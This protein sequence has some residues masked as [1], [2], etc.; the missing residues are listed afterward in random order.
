[1]VLAFEAMGRDM[2][3]GRLNKKD[4]IKEKRKLLY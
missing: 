3:V 4:Y 2:S 1:M